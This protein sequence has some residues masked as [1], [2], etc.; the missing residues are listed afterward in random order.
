MASNVYTPGPVQGDMKALEKMASG[1]KRAGGTYG[2]LVQI[3]EPGRPPGSG[4]TQ[5]PIQ[6]APYNA[7][8]NEHRQLMQVY[9]DAK[10]YADLWTAAESDPSAGSWVRMY[11]S[12]ARQKAMDAANN[13]KQ[14]T[15]DFI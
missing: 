9:A 4:T 11:A 13:L 2:P 8:P 1:V 3:P 10:R 15:P 7:I 14:A 6:E 12:V 5:S